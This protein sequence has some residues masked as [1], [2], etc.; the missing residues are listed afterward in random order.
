[1]QKEHW[2][3]WVLAVADISGDWS[4]IPQVRHG[5][6]ECLALLVSSFLP[7][8]DGATHNQG[9]FSLLTK[10]SLERPSQT[11]PEVCL[12]GD[13]KSS[14]GDSGNYSHLSDSIF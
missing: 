12:L 5:G 2:W 9:T 6:D 10:T 7:L 4:L 3:D 8:Y 1:M 14:H 11:H 13:F